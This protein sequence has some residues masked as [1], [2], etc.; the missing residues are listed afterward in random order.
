MAFQ[1]A[2]S[3]ATLDDKTHRRDGHIKDMNPDEE[4][5]PLNSKLTWPYFIQDIIDELYRNKLS[6]IMVIVITLIS[7]ITVIILPFV[8]G[9]LESPYAV[10]ILI[11]FGSFTIIP[12]MFFYVKIFLR[13]R[14]KTTQKSS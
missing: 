13:V 9:F 12:V 14:K 1:W 4:E 8:E 10:E 2:L 6:L 5:H 3:D 7:L 11:F